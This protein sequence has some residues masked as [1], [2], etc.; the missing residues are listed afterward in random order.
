MIN[1]EE[2]AEK[3][4]L[5]DGHY[6]L[7]RP[8]S[9]DGATADV[10][11]ALDTN[12]IDTEY[13]EEGSAKNADNETGM[14]VAIKIYKPKNA[15]DTE[16]EQRFRDEYKI[17]YECRHE[18]LLQP[19]SFAIY[20]GI[21]YLV[22]PYCKNGSSEQFIGKKQ[23]EEQM[24]KFISDVSSGLAKL[25]SN[26]P[27]IVHQDIKPANILIDHNNNF[28]ITD[29]GISSSAQG[30]H[31]SY[32]GE[33]NSGTLAYMAPERFSGDPKP[34]AESDIW[35]FGATLCE[36]LTGFVPFGENGGL[37]QTDNRMPKTLLS[38]L[39][40]DVKKLILAC[41]QRDPNK[42]PTA[43]K[44]MEIAHDRRK[45]R[46]W[47]PIVIILCVLAIGAVL[48]FVTNGAK[49]EEE[50]TILVEDYEHAEEMLSTFNTAQ[51]GF[52]LLQNLVEQKDYDATFLMS[53]LY[54]DASD[55]RDTLFYDRKWNA[56]RSYCKVNADNKQAHNLLM[57]A[58][59][60]NDYDYVL[61]YQLGSDFLSG[62]RRGCERNLDY[63]RWC[64]EQGE[65]ALGNNNDPKSNLYREYIK[66]GIQRT[67]GF[68]AKKPQN[69]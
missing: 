1:I 24:W 28:T 54:F 41:L 26:Q 20:K 3:G 64:F 35:A 6:K 37:N 23:T 59:E 49:T 67:E 62:E 65:R 8:L 48:F 40:K 10:W 9:T 50:E 16:G 17:V 18:N 46:P 39:P 5:F 58:F 68:T 11:L 57:E 27:Q 38:G 45:K 51:Q 55:N 43:Q 61:L 4:E 66:K 22:L 19:T 29:F 42:R 34:S 53:R 2:L 44:I 14:M 13:D 33:E 47:L 60:I 63:A 31:A 30:S 12:T 25:H 32:Y 36:I 56:M 15:L 7:V 69:D 52:E 21:P